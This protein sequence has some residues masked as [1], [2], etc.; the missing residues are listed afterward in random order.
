MTDLKAGDETRRACPDEGTCHHGC[1]VGRPCFRVLCCGPLSGVY[2]RDEW[3]QDL[4]ESALQL[5]DSGPS[6]R[7]CR[8]CLRTLVGEDELGWYYQVPVTDPEVPGLTFMD[9]VH[10]CGGQ[11]HNVILP[12]PDA[13]HGI[14][15]ACPAC[16][17]YDGL[18]THAD[19]PDS[20]HHGDLFSRIEASQEG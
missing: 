2:P 20:V 8:R 13:P 5:A 11:P 7:K 15:C 12:E 17:D 14:G 6:T 19:L 3:P 9:R 1:E 16:P 18:G 10:E 4:R